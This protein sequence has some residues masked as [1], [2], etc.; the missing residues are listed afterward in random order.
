MNQG[1]AGAPILPKTLRQGGRPLNLNRNLLIET[2]ANAGLTVKFVLL[3]LIGMSVVCW[4]II[5]FKLFL[6]R[7][8]EKGS[9]QFSILFSQGQSLVDIYQASR[10]LSK[11]PLKE[12]FEAGYRELA[13]LL[14]AAGG[15]P[16][17]S[18]E[19]SS[20]DI[21]IENIGR[22]LK[23]AQTQV[24][25]DLESALT[26]LATT[27]STAPFIGLFGTVWGIM[28]AFRT[29]GATGSANLATVA[30]GIA[31]ALIAT[32][33]GLFAAIPAVVAYN[34]FLNWVKVIASEMENFSSDFLNIIERHLRTL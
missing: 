27:G 31:E 16:R 20:A 28:T 17:A 21:S 34:Y 24:V 30:P 33:V 32:A 7:R 18:Q 29:I 12:V 5:L 14:K 11:S 26:F 22:A 25:T 13:K 10:H 3:V 1:S 9:K 23:K 4:G 2:F 6:F 8:C 15:A 19:A